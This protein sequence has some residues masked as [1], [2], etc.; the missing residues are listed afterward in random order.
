VSARFVEYLVIG[1]GIA[2]ASCAQ[3]LREGGATGSIVLAGRELDE[4]YHRPP[5]TKGYLTGRLERTDSLINPPEWWKDNEVELLTRTSVMSLDLDR[6]VATLQSKDEIEFGKALV[7]T[8][9]MVRRLGVDGS[10]L[11]GIH[12][13][14]TL[15]NADALRSDLERAER[16]VCVGGSY[17]ACEVAASLAELGHACTL[18]MQEEVTLE[19]G[20]GRIAGGWVQRGLEERGVC[21]IASDEVERFAGEDERLTGVVTRGGRELEA[22]VVVAGVG[23]IPDVMLAR[24]AGL[25]LGEL[26]GV[27]TSATLETSADG[28]FAAGDM[29]EY[30]SVVHGRPMRIEHEEVAAAQ[31]ATVARNMLGAGE[32]HR[33]VPYFFSDL[34]DWAALEYVG[35]AQSWDD[36]VVRGSLDDG[37]FSVWY[38]ED[39]RVRAALSVG[40]P[41]DLDHARRLIVAGT[42]VGERREE[43]A[44]VGFGLE[45][46]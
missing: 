32:P 1:G 11:E 42:D 43:L 2:S 19:R 41:G 39:G 14:R 24:R 29:C 27:K 7:A 15:G 31:G 20:F 10:D 35:P 33:E 3:G 13:L 25:E 6:R 23:A 5:I 18:V 22:D 8:G 12:Y 9:A 28:I 21:V 26:G 40:R 45:G 17:I 16:V 38:L 37:E 30:D 4:P 46:L 34:S 44:A 36:D